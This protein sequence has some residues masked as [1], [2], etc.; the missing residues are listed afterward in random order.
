MDSWSY[1]ITITGLSGAWGGRGEE[2]GLERT[3][4]WEEGRDSSG[5]RGCSEDV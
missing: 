4:H 5:L 1:P 3:A 2:Q